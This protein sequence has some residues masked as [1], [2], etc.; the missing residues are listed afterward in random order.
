MTTTSDRD[1]D[2]PL[3][4]ESRTVRIL[5]VEDDP[6]FAELVKTFLERRHE[7]FEVHVETDSRAA[8]AAITDGS[9]TFDCVVSDYDVP[10]LNG[11]ELLAEIRSENPNMPFILYTGKGSEE[12]AS[13]AISAGVTDYLQKG[14]GTDQY[15]VL[16]NRIQNVVGHYWAKRDAN[17]A[18]KAI[19]TAP[20]GVSILDEAGHIQYL[21]SAYADLLGYE[22]EELVGA[23]WETFYA[24]EDIDEVYDA[25]L[26]QA[27]KDRWR[28][29]TSF[30][31]KGGSSIALDHTV[32]ATDDGSLICTLSPPDD[33][34][35]L[36]RELSTRERAMDE[37]PIGIV[38][39]DP[40][41]D[42]NPIVYA[43]DKFVDI[44]GYE[45]SAVVGRNCRLL[46]G[47]NTSEEAVRE[48]RT[49]VDE[50]EP[51]TVELRNYR[52]DGTEFW[53]RVR[54]APIFDEDGGVEFFVGF[55]DDV[56]ERHAYQERLRANTARLEALFD[57]SPDM[58]LTHDA[59]G[60]IRDIN[61]R[62]C[63]EL[64]YSESELLG[65][66]VWDID[67]TVDPESAR[68]F[69]ADLPTNAPRRFEGEFEREDGSTFP[70]EIHLIRVDLDG[71]ERFVAMARDV[72]DQKTRER[73]LIRQNERLDRFTSVVSHDLRN[74]LQVAQGRLDLLSEECDSEHAAAIEG[75][76]D[77]MDALIEDLL[78]LAQ[79]GTSAME[80]ERVDLGELARSCWT[81]VDTAAATL[82]VDPEG[83][84][85]GDRELLQQ[86]FENLFRNAVEHV[87]ADVTVT[88]GATASGFFVA[89]DG[90]GIPV[91]E[92]E[93]V[94]EVGHST[95]SN[96][97]GL[98]LNIVEQ[99]VEAHGGR[100][101]VIESESGGARF[102]VSGLGG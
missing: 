38:L 26:P 16:A 35:E 31:R 29:R 5:H 64:G 25:L 58:L 30:V 97:T 45:R 88:V 100:V 93:A 89:D 95:S 83:T 96:G 37:A 43:N 94:F 67:V 56:T 9:T 84:V 41:A 70:V 48:L 14:G 74:P 50:R 73:E 40:N 62:I 98:G 6:G 65:N 47:E 18:L 75:A 63:E 52:A 92:R 66:A 54:I 22:R 13:E 81:T 77:R 87:G 15:H 82:V 34:A 2:H 24:D 1:P 99:V 51:A 49:A 55:Q 60:R 80:L 46:Q 57:H 71:I 69:W 21:N 17:C 44:T 101:E 39:T 79:D 4:A 68:S 76:L 53:N 42:D 59:D 85:E 86:L 28:G 10:D 7:T 90:P 91:D 32:T 20:D 12:I 3:L 27:R 23:H 102:E 19:E 8:L 33:S 36:S 11:L 78:T 72:S 61:R